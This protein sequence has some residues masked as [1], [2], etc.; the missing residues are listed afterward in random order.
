MAI[1]PRRKLKGAALKRWKAA[2]KASRASAIARKK[3][4]LVKKNPWSARDVKRHNKKCASKTRC[5]NKWAKIANAVL[6]TSKDEGKAVRIANWQVNRMGLSRRRNPKKIQ[7]WMRR[8]LPRWEVFIKYDR[9]PGDPVWGPVEKKIEKIVK[10]YTGAAS[11]FHS[12]RKDEGFITWP[13]WPNTEE[14]MRKLRDSL[15]K[16]KE[17]R[18]V[19]IKEDIMG[20]S[21]TTY[22]KFK[23][24]GQRRTVKR[25]PS[26]RKTHK[27]L[28]KGLKPRVCCY[29]KTKSAVWNMPRDKR[30]RTRMACTKCLKKKTK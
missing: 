22:R 21:K 30:G 13:L 23:E 1:S 24:T 11:D 12:A 9:S 20:M 18:E 28:R 15:H 27:R 5:R 16:F 4:K 19:N 25:N 7:P 26:L 8:D 6:R 3:K 29:C 17:V 14:E 10:K 2:K